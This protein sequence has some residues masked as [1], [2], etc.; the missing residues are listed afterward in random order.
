MVPVGIKP[1]QGRA[2]QPARGRPGAP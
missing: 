1:V 2:D